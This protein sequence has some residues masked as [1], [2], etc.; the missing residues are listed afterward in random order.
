MTTSSIESF[1]DELAQ[2][3]H[4]SW[5]EQE[6]GRVRIELVDAECIRQWTLTFQ[7]GD[8]EVSRFTGTESDV[9][10]VLRVDRTLFERAI[11]GEANLLQAVLRGELTFAGSIELLA[12]LGRLL[13][14][15]PGQRGPRR[16]TGRGGDK[17]EQ[18][19][20]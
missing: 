18:Q 19:H 10:V 7:N 12:S 14:G 6:H 20:D 16:V 2:V 3:R 17:R 5:L 9:D 13:P 8:V 15:P 11:R 4:V 1:F